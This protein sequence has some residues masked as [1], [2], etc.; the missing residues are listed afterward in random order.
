MYMCMKMEL[1]VYSNKRL[2]FHYSYIQNK[3]SM[4]QPGKV[5]QLKY[6]KYSPN[7]RNKNY[8]MHNNA[9]MICLHKIYSRKIFQI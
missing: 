5:Y 4:L 8:N 9:K 2:D 3:S 1:D 7:Y 6:N